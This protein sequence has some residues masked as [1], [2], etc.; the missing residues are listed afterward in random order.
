MK[1]GG[2]GGANTQTGIHFEKKTDLLVELG[3][4]PEFK[5]DGN[6]VLKNGVIVAENCRQ[7]ALYRF[8]KKKGVNFS[9][10]V[11][12]KLLPDEALYIPAQKRM[13]IIEKKF[14]EKERSAMRKSQASR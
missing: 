9:D 4:L 6:N 2:I 7:H 3:K 5:I 12:A 13:Y 11:S 10:H 1:K 8:L 14:Q